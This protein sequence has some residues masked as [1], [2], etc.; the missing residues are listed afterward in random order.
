MRTQIEQV[1]AQFIALTTSF[2]QGFWFS[3]Q[4]LWAVP[5]ALLRVGEWMRQLYFAGVLSLLIIM[6]AGFFVGMVLALQGYN[7]LVSFNA[8]EIVGQ[9]V[10]LSLLRELGPV[11]AALLFAGR[12]GSAL[13]AELGLMKSTEQLSALE[14]MGLDPVKRIFAPRFIAVLLALPML[15]MLFSVMGILGGYLVAVPG[16]SVDDGAFWAQIQAS[17]SWDED[18]INSMI[19]SLVF[20]VTIGLVALFQGV[21]AMPTAEGVSRATTNTVVHS[22]LLVLGLDFVLTALMFN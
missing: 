19:K 15:A 5:S 11:V 2:A 13:T 22:S 12:A 18:V 17:V 10:A 7:I 9:M 3:L 20:A 8:T 16:L 4:L 14:M 1:G 6:V 21:Q